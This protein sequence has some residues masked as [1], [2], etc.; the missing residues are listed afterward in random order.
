VQRID[1]QAL[2]ILTAALGL[3]GDGAQVTELNDATV[4]QA[5]EIGPIVRRSRTLAGSEG[6]FVGFMENVHGAGGGQ[7][8]SITP[9]DFA[10]AN[11]HAPYP[12]RVPAS[13]EIWLL[14]ASMEQSAGALTTINGN[15]YA[16]GHL[17]SFGVDQLGADVT[18]L[19]F[20]NLVHFNLVTEDLGF[21]TLVGSLGT[22][23]PAFQPIGIRLPRQGNPTLIWSTNA[24]AAS[25]FSLSIYM[26]LFPVALGQ[27]GSV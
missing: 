26:G 8:S 24:G 20:L 19:G 15:L 6:L 1:S 25:T 23:G 11:A 27:D 16:S 12:S 21:T 9:Y 14:G 18:Q 2:G 17:Q 22:D 4:E 7:Q 13:L 5:L 3:S 10:A